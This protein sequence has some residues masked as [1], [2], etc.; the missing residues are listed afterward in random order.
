MVIVYGA[1]WC[2]DT[3]RSRR[4]LRRLAVRHQYVDVDRDLTALERA[5]SLNNG[6]RRTPTIEIAGDVF[7]EPSNEAL[8]HALVRHTLITEAE[9]GERQALQ[10]V[11]DLER[12]LR[13][14][15]GLLALLVAASGPKPRWPLLVLGAA[16]VLTG[17]TGWCP[18]YAAGRVSSLEG[19]GDRPPEAERRAWLAEQPD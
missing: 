2:E 18:L 13:V 9:V 7:V 10:N 17:T 19:P 3:E 14:S 6:R 8:R 1:D 4:L 16:G 15:G 5:K 11:G 12:V